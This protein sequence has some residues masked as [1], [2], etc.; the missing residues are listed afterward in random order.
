MKHQKKTQIMKAF[1]PAILLISG[2]SVSL[3]SISYQ[4]IDKAIVLVNDEI[5]FSSELEKRIQQ[6]KSSTQNI[7]NENILRER[8]S[9]QLIL[10]KLQL[11]IAERNNITASEADIK[12]GLQQTERNLRRNGITLQQFLQQQNTSRNALI[13]QISNEII[14]KN[15]QQAA[16]K[17]RVKI[18]DREIDN[19]LSSKEGQEWL[20]PKYR[21]GHIFLPFKKGAKGEITRNAKAVYKRLQNPSVDFGKVAQQVSKG[22]N[23]AKGGDLGSL[24]KEELPEIFIEKIIPLN[25]G[26]TTPPFASP[27]G[28]HILRL[29]TRSGAEPVIVDQ[30]KVRHILVKSTELFTPQEAETKI[31]DIHNQLL[32]KP[33]FITLA[34]ENT[35][36]IGSKLDGGDLGWSIP[37][38]FVPEFERVMVTTP[39]GKFSQ[40]FQT[41]FGWHI[42]LVE[43]KRQ[44][45]IFEQVKR[46]QVANLIGRQRFQDELQIWLQELRDNA[47]VEILN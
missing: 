9:E 46:K 47:S 19:F 41:Q 29:L 17:Q 40:P 31:K 7:R 12:R 13:K 21:V 24:T 10:E 44:K 34:E 30:F 42:L 38:K 27:A 43:D 22:P 32:K 4:K 8:V 16:V 18:T 6:A 20:T 45:D 11:K 26:D 14:I 3:P 1:I 5:I 39:V 25:I 33:D 37:G 15:V 2:M 35:D 23:A 36:D 28:I